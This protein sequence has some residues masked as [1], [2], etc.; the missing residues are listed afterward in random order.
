MVL[1]V[2]NQCP[3]RTIE[4]VL[5]SQQFFLGA[6]LIEVISFA[7]G[8][9]AIKNTC[10]DLAVASAVRLMSVSIGMKMQ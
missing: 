10:I 8:K 9:N 3:I 6:L 7:I 1:A 5:G 4:I 2:E